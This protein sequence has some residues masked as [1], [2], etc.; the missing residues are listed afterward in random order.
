MKYEINIASNITNGFQG[1]TADSFVSKGILHMIITWTSKARQ[2]CDIPLNDVS[3][4]VMDKT[5]IGP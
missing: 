5:S 3:L 2:S 4:G 1:V